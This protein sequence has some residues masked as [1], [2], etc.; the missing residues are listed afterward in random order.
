MITAPQIVE[1]TAQ[2]YA[3]IRLWVTLSEFSGVIPQTHDAVIKWVQ[4]QG[5]T[6]T[7]P[8]FIRYL[9]INMEEKMHVELGWPVGQELVSDEQVTAG[10][11]PAG[12]YG[13]VLYTGDYSG[14]MDANRVLVEWAKENKI[15]WDRWDDEKGDAFAARLENY[16]LDPGNDPDPAKWETEVVIK[17]ADR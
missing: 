15:E 13:H 16:I 5:A 8:S 1:R 2:P 7:G 3:G 17:L 6:V 4:E 11:I 12:R 9:V 14:L 10:V